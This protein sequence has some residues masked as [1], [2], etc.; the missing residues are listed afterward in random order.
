MSKIRTAGVVVVL[1]LMSALFQ[2]QPSS[3]AVPDASVAVN[4]QA[5]EGQRHTIVGYVWARCAPGFRFTSLTINITQGQSVG[6]ETGRSVDCD[7]LW[8]KQ[9]FTT[10]EENWVPGPATVTATLKVTHV[11]TGYSGS[12]GTQTKQIYVRPGAKIELPATAVLR[13]HNVVKLVLK[14]RCDK[15]WVLAEFG[16]EAQQGAF[17]RLASDSFNSDTFPN[18]DGALHS[19]TLYLESSPT[20]FERGWITVSAHIHT[21]DPVEFDPAPSTTVQRA[22]KVN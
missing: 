15:P 7:G 20:A 11:Q 4:P 8:H 22:V 21:L 18:C 14:A 2:S 16:L 19:L 5:Y 9:Q 10:S 12:P 6:T 3:A 1:A 13:P 17:P